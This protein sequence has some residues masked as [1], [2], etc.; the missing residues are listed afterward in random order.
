MLEVKN[1]SYS[2]QNVSVLENISYT[3]K[4]GTIYSI[5]GASGVGKS[6]FLALISGLE[7]LQHG[8]VHFKGE[9]IRDV[10]KYR[11]KIAYIFQALN[12]IPY[13][14]PIENICVATDIHKKKN[15]ASAAIYL[16]LL[17]IEGELQTKKCHQLSGG[18]Q[19]RVAI[20]RSLALDTDLIIA[21][22][23]TGSLDKGNSQ[24]IMKAFEKLRDEGKCVIIV[25]HDHAFAESADE[26]LTLD[27]GQLKKLTE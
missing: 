15:N 12:L 13:L 8:E 9:I 2:Y 20:A 7:F 21:D 19:Q 1:I 10:V 23:P 16:N 3:F 14:S 4:K 24:N 27:Q 5:I 11:Q 6:T 17:G 18:Q 22:E 25:T 26:V